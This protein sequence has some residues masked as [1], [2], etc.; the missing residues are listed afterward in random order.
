VAVKIGRFV[1]H[2]RSQFKKRV[3]RIADCG[4]RIDCGLIA[5]CAANPKSHS[6]I[7][8]PQIRNPQSEI[9]NSQLQVEPHAS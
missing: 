5:D 8:N 6:V 7:R 3:F 2:P 4:L 9:R 1:W